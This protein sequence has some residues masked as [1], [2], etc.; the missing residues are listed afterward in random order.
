[1][2]DLDT[3]R[4]EPLVIDV[5]LRSTREVVADAALALGAAAALAALA[6]A[7]LAPIAAEWTRTTARAEPV[8]LVDLELPGG[9]RVAA[10]VE[11]SACEPVASHDAGP[12]ACSGRPAVE[13]LPE[14]LLAVPIELPSCPGVRIIEWRTD[15]R[16][17]QFGPTAEHLAT[18]DSGCRK[19]MYRFREF[20]RI[21]RIR[22]REVDRPLDLPVSVVPENDEPRSL[23]DTR[24]RFRLRA[25]EAARPPP[26]I[27]GYCHHRPLYVVL[28]VDGPAENTMAHEVFHAMSFHYGAIALD[29]G[30][31]AFR[32]ARDELRAQAFTEMLGLGR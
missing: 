2:N 19:A 21:A 14:E 1:M 31:L 11:A 4:P 12:L 17:P 7:V 23:N 15:P 13:P 3:S 28:T 24:F 9:L 29:T 6:L 20:V 8:D 27:W 32:L 18:L 30:P 22:V 26:R 10:C 5:P 16:R 25:L